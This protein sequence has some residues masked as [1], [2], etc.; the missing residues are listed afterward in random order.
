MPF[1]CR[2]QRHVP[3]FALPFQS[4]RHFSF[5]HSDDKIEPIFGLISEQS[6]A[7]DGGFLS[8]PITGE[9]P[10]RGDPFLLKRLLGRK[11]CHK[12]TLKKGAYAQAHR[13]I[14]LAFKVRQSGIKLAVPAPQR[15]QTKR[16]R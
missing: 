6:Q 2:H 11:G 3:A 1:E 14:P 12:G 13:P 15:E 9:P 16:R 7:R 8:I 4:C 10:K 5:Q